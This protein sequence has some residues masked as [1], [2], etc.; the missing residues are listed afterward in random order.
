MA[1]YSYNPDKKKVDLSQR[2]GLRQS[3]G[4]VPVVFSSIFK[5]K[6]LIGVV[7][8]FLLLVVIVG[9]GITGDL[10][11]QDSEYD[12]LSQNPDF[13]NLAKK[14]ANLRLYNYI[15]DFTDLQSRFDGC[16]SALS[17]AQEIYSNCNSEK[18]RIMSDLQT[19]DSNLNSCNVN[20]ANLKSNL[21]SCNSEKSTKDLNLGTCNS[22]LNEKGALLS[23]LES[24]N[25]AIISN[26]ASSVCCTLQRLSNPSLKYYT[27][28]NNRVICSDTEGNEFSCD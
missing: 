28:V 17:D 19:A 27:V 13:P 3:G 6:M 4:K 26:Y 8:A 18:V 12:L 10:L 1:E 16:E 20:S 24:D 11:Y 21:D 15:G 9:P 22:A 2:S 23:K 7:T 14:E 25:A 5:N